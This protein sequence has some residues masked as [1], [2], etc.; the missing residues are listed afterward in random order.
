MGTVSGTRQSADEGKSAITATGSPVVNTWPPARCYVKTAI[1]TNDDIDQTPH[2]V[3]L[4]IPNRG[5]NQ[6]RDRDQGRVHRLA[7]KHPTAFEAPPPAVLGLRRQQVRHDHLH[8]STWSDRKSTRLNSS[9][10]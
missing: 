1:S 9:H 7:D 10:L 6:T 8:D 3:G 5:P 4:K 2:F